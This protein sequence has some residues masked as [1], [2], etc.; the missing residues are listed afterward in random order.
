M[1]KLSDLDQNEVLTFAEEFTNLDGMGSSLM[2]GSVL[3][4]AL[5]GFPP[6]EYDVVLIM[7]KK[8]HESVDMEDGTIQYAIVC[9]TTA[10]DEPTFDRLLNEALIAN[11]QQTKMTKKNTH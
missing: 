7:R 6:E 11:A 1:K 5:S 4:M 2:R 8:D 3:S 9:V 10:M